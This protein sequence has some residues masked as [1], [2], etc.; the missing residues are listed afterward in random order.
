MELPLCY[1]LTIIPF[2][3]ECAE[4][5]ETPVRWSKAVLPLAFYLYTLRKKVREIRDSTTT[6]VSKVQVTDR[7]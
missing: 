1:R 3:T 6:V 2:Y 4:D 7:R 5:R